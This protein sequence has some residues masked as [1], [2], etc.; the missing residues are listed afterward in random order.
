MFTSVMSAVHMPKFKIQKFK[1]V[2]SWR[3]D[4]EEA[5]LTLFDS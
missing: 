4:I 2:T 1:A 5:I 3:T